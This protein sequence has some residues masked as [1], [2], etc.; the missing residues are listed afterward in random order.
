ML[1]RNSL[2][3]CIGDEY[4]ELQ[5]EFDDHRRLCAGADR[6]DDTAGSDAGQTY[7]SGTGS[8]AGGDFPCPG[9][10]KR[11]DESAATPDSSGDG[12]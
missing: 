1:T 5:K 6:S 11:T 9:N 12:Y 10:G 7:K 3:H 4:I 2:P 8:E